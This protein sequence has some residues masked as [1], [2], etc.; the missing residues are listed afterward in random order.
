MAKKMI[1]LGTGP[2][3]LDGDKIRVAFGKVND[4]FTELYDR[5]EIIEVSEISWDQ[6]TD[7]P[8]IPTDISDLTDNQGLLDDTL[9]G[10]SA[11]SGYNNEENIDGGGA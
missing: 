8:T 2:N 6:I 1:N 3:T 5:V 10:G 7:K 9:D 11:A 4:N